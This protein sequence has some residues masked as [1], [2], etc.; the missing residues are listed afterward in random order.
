[1]TRRSP[2]EFPSIADGLAGERRKKRRVLEG[3]QQ[4]YDA[5]L[6]SMLSAISY[7]PENQHSTDAEQCERLR[8]G[9]A[10]HR[11]KC[12]DVG[13]GDFAVVVEVAKKSQAVVT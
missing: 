11:L 7:P 5:G 10:H 2:H 12:D 4:R 9:N 13:E 3:Q 8:F 6:R 1:M